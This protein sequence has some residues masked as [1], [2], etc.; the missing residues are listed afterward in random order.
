MSDPSNLVRCDFLHS[1]GVMAA[2]WAGNAA[3]QPLNT[4]S[5][6]SRPEQLGTRGLKQLRSDYRV[7]LFQTVLPFWNQP[8]STTNAAVSCARRTTMGHPVLLVGSGCGRQENLSR[9][10]YGQATYLLAS[11][12]Q[13]NFVP[14][15][16]RQD[17]YHPLR[18][19]M[20]NLLVLNRLAETT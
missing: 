13:M 16:T 18:R 3:A 14:K 19:L 9:Q 8:A 4:D 20:R 12:R 10:K 17:N 11:D 5:S 1:A 15:S 7:E 6:P 2:G